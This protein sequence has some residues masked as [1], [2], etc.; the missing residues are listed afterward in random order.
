MPNL[1]LNGVVGS[2]RPADTFLVRALEKIISDKEVK[3]SNNAQLKK[4]CE[5]ML[6]ELKKDAKNKPTT[7]FIQI[8]D[9]EKYFLPFE[10]SCKCK[11]PRV[12]E[13][14]L[15]CIQKLIAHGYLNEPNCADQSSVGKQ[16]LVQRITKTI[17]HCFEGPHI[18]DLVQL[19]IVKVIII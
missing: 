12:V 15:D 4:Q 13:T 8:S 14:A 11:S 10:M 19:Q 2:T 9:A 6:N 16:Q 18:D 7:Q 17:C 5:S 3:R 1:S